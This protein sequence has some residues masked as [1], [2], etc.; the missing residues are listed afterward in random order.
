MEDAGFI[1]GSYALCAAAVLAL[2][3]RAVRQSR[4]L[5]DKISDDDKYWL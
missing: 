5:A 4:K 1:L 2:A 3:W